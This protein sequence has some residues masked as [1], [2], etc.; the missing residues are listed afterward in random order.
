MLLR[1]WEYLFQLYSREFIK[2]GGSK[3]Q[4]AI[5][6]ITA[7]PVWLYKNNLASNVDLIVNSSVCG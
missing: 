1:I 4:C 2:I 7:C 5:D 3:I 6:M